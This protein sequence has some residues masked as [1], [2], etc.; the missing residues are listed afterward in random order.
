MVNYQEKKILFWSYLHQLGAT[1]TRSSFFPPISCVRETTRKLET[2]SP[3]NLNKEAWSCSIRLA[4]PP[5][6]INVSL[7]CHYVYRTPMPASIYGDLGTVL[8]VLRG[9]IMSLSHY[10]L[11]R[12]KIIAIIG[13][14]LAT[15]PI[16]AFLPPRLSGWAACPPLFICH[17]TPASKQE[18]SKAKLFALKCTFFSF[19][20]L[21]S[22][23][24]SASRTSDLP[25][26]S[27]MPS[28]P[29]QPWP[30]ACPSRSLQRRQNTGSCL[31]WETKATHSFT[32]RS[33]DSAPALPILW[34]SP[35]GMKEMNP[36]QPSIQG[37]PVST[38]NIRL[39]THKPEKTS[40]T[41]SF[42]TLRGSVLQ[43]LGWFYP[44]CVSAVR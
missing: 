42:Q 19:L 38:L 37:A 12:K 11:G 17:N 43:L 22:N 18:V 30:P 34:P 13:V 28:S 15:T 41:L 32:R 9:P 6:F 4:P 7:Q 40:T 24:V 21:F 3:W 23:F 39:L 8:W 16:F 44:R 33:T 14:R 25:Q 31:A 1:L 36:Q 10:E 26:S 27:D 5:L 35:V 20:L 29:V 2:V